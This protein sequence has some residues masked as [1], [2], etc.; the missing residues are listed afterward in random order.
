MGKGVAIY[1][2]L[3]MLPITAI[4][5]VATAISFLRT[6]KHLSSKLIVNIWLIFIFGTIILVLLEPLGRPMILTQKHIVGTY[7]IDRSKFPG[8]QAD[9]QYQNFRFTITNDDKLIF[10]SR[11]NDSKWKADTV[12]VTYSSGY[13]DSKIGEYCNRKLRVHTDSAHHHII[14]DNP[15]LYR[16]SNDKFYYVFDSKKFGNVFFKR[17]TWKE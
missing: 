10:E 6:K 15:T 12:K 17:G 3:F 13:H 1:L 7:V 8:K 4:Y 11:I 14:H 9:W 5:L 2:F 16:L